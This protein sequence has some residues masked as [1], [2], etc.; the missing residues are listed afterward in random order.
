MAK[1]YKMEKLLAMMLMLLPMIAWGQVRIEKSASQIQAE[2]VA[3]SLRIVKENTMAV[4]DSLSNYVKP[5]SLFLLIGQRIII[6][7][8][9]RDKEPY[10]GFYN[11]NGDVYAKVETKYSQVGCAYDSLAGRTFNVIGYDKKYPRKLYIADEKDSLYMTNSADKY[12]LIEG[13]LSKL[14]K[15]Y[16]GQKYVR[17]I[18]MG[19]NDETDF[20]TGKSFKVYAG[21]VWTIKR[22]IINPENGD[23]YAILSNTKGQEVSERLVG[24]LSFFDIYYV[25]KKESDKWRRKYG[26]FCWKKILNKEIYVGMPKSAVEL[27]WGEPK[28]INDA[29]YGEQW[30]YSNGYVYIKNG[31]VT[32]WN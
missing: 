23:I 20:N 12:Y 19:E 14:A 25:P 6:K 15:K 26:D 8:H 4:Y 28:Y 16:E 27:A 32:G 5:D 2:R 29:S 11:L 22:L 17:A 7:P 1:I 21:Q 24:W 30:V 10:Q 31:K 13:Y 3:D 9:E 18:N